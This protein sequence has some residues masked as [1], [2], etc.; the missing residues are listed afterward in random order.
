[1]RS[2]IFSSYIL[3][4]LTVPKLLLAQSQDN[5]NVNSAGKDFWL[6][7]F[8][9][10][11]YNELQIS[12]KHYATVTVTYTSNNSS[13]THN[14]TPGTVL[15]IPQNQIVLAINNLVETV[16]NNSMHISSDSNIV[17][18]YTSWGIMTDD[19][20]LIYPSDRQRYG[21]TFFLNGLPFLSTG[22]F[23]NRAGGYSIVATCDSVQLKITPSKNT[24]THNASVPFLLNLNKGQTYTLTNSGSNT[25]KDL[26][27]TKVEVIKASCCNPINIFNTGICGYSY[28]P[29]TG[30]VKLA[31]DLFLEQVLPTS[32]W[33][34][35]YPVVPYQN[36]PFSIY[37]IV[38]S[39]ANNSVYLNG[40]I[41]AN[42]N[43]GQFLDTI[44]NQPVIITSDAPI[45]ISQNMVAYSIAY[46]NPNPIP[47]QDIPADSLSDPNT[48]LLQP[49]GNGIKEAYFKTIGQTLL[50]DS[51]MYNKLHRL[52]LISKSE[53]VNS[54]MLNNVSIASAF[55]PF[56][57]NPAYQYAS[58]KP[59]TGVNHHLISSDRIIAY[60]YA[61]TFAGSIDFHLG[62]V[63]P[64]RFYDE[65]PTDTLTACINESKL[66]N[67]QQSA[68][69]EWSTGEVTQSITA[70]DTGMYEVYTYEDDDCPGALKK[71]V[72][73]RPNSYINGFDIGN[74][75]TICEGDAITIN[76]GYPLTQWSTG[77]IGQRLTTETR[78]I[79]FATI[80]DT[81]TAYSLSDTIIINDTTCLD[82]YCE[83]KFPNAFTPNN[84]G[85][86]DI[87]LPYYFGNFTRY[88]LNIYN[89]FGERVFNSVLTDKGWDGTHKNV[90]AEVGVYYYRCVFNCPLKGEVQLSGDITLLR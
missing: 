41:I 63:N 89:R 59:D 9:S 43:E 77:H 5:V 14:I 22:Y 75:T 12:S 11:R 10:S 81:C 34:T 73:K 90:P 36:A 58:I 21:S 54:I 64:V 76:S 68:F 48:A 52:I 42:L 49:F 18:Q 46:S 69:Y 51:E 13:T 79:Y 70:S 62:D 80:T 2:I 65:L 28:W 6:T 24:A 33:D 74:D 35:L 37:K 86:N 44:L 60:Y 23:G 20:M 47:V 45:S 1:M 57:S 30:P 40:T 32:A 87:F 67:A 61:T 84:D 50:A 88:S 29:Y 7:L 25:T 39:A 71:F 16:Q 82:K 38:S 31:C 78:G 55:I 72:I 3:L 85:L 19:G 83:F 27:G 66:L 8:A 56:P 26:S 4:L 53:N 15:S 17:V